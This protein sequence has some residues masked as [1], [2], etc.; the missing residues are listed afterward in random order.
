[1]ASLMAVLGTL[2]EIIV[3][4]SEVSADTQG[5]V[6]YVPEYKLF[7]IQ[8]V[9]YTVNECTLSYANQITVLRSLLL[10]S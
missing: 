10:K 4:P 8:I 1:M 5:L 9:H 3:S 7:D 6:K 2:N